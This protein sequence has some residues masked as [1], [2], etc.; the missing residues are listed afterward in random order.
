[1]KHAT[2]ALSLRNEDNISL[3]TQ[4]MHMVISK[5]PHYKVQ[6]QHI[7]ANQSEKEG[8]HNAVKFRETH[9]KL[10]HKAPFHLADKT[11]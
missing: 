5:R 1:M 3:I 4:V 7:L 10:P 9:P 6:A 8:S 2:A 11:L